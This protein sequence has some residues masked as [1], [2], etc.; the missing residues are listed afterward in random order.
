MSD[1]E[2]QVES[3]EPERANRPYSID[4]A[5]ELEASLDDDEPLSAQSN[6]RPLSMDT[7]V[8]QSL[9]KSLRESLSRAE[10]QRDEARFQ[11]KE[12]QEILLTERAGFAETMQS[13]TDRCT[14]LEDEAITS[15]LKSDADEQ[16]I[17]VLR[18][19]VEESRY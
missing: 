10:S 8:L 19:K 5:L 4:A 15:K 16:S 18:S 6:N 17:S 14:R 1:H 9:I 12:A 7:T 13:L 11:A 3:A 2:S